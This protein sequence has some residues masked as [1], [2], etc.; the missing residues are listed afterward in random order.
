MKRLFIL[1]RCL[2]DLLPFRPKVLYSARLTQPI[3]PSFVSV[4]FPHHRIVSSTSDAFVPSGWIYFRSKSDSGKTL[5]S[6]VHTTKSICNS[7]ATPLWPLYPTNFKKIINLQ[8]TSCLTVSFF[9]IFLFIFYITPALDIIMLYS[10]MC[11]IITFVQTIRRQL[12]PHIEHENTTNL[13]RTIRQLTFLSMNEPK[14]TS[15]RKLSNSHHHYIWHSRQLCFLSIHKCTKYPSWLSSV[16]LCL[17]VW[18]IDCLSV[19][20]HSCSLRVFVRH[21]SL[22]V[23]VLV[24][25]MNRSNAGSCSRTAWISTLFIN[26]HGCGA[27]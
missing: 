16:S 24:L 21:I 26:N 1:H 19:S 15:Q 8:N 13:K 23:Y 11:I 27:Q 20:L 2:L 14:H 3:P 10:G 12:Y 17:F 7:S 18:L 9:F 25:I 6:P 22:S 5:S 4:A